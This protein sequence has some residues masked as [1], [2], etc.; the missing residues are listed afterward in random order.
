MRYSQTYQLI[1]TDEYAPGSVY[2]QS[3]V[4]T[5]TSQSGYA[6]LMGL[7][8]PESSTST[9]FSTALKPIDLHIPFGV[10]GD[11]AKL[12]E[13]NSIGGTQ[14]LSYGFTAI[15]VMMKNGL[16]GDDDDFY[17]K[18]VFSTMA[19]KPEDYYRYTEQERKFI[20][21]KVRSVVKEHLGLTQ[22]ET[23][24]ANIVQLLDYSDFLLSH[25]FEGTIMTKDSNDE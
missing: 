5:R 10:R 1:G 18:S 25:F 14:G 9:S 3:T 6:S 8:P 12:L 4:Q 7:Y 24:N 19:K 21:G 16:I 13:D 17:C 2:V 23:E 15:P 11:Q 20:D 22:S